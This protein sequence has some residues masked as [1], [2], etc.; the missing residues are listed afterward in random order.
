MGSRC[1]RW[2]WN[3]T[4]AL[5]SPCCGAG[6]LLRCWLPAAAHSLRLAAAAVAAAAALR[7]LSWKQADVETGQHTLRCAAATPSRSLP[8]VER[9]CLSLRPL[10]P[11]ATPARWTSTPASTC[12]SLAASTT[13]SRRRCTWRVGG[14]GWRRAGARVGGRVGVPVGGER[15]SGLRLWVEALPATWRELACKCLLAS[16]PVYPRPL[17]TLSCA[18]STSGNPYQRRY[19]SL[20]DCTNKRGSLVQ[21]VASPLL[22]RR[23]HQWQ[24][25][26]PGAPG[27]SAAAGHDCACD[28]AGEHWP[29][30]GGGGTRGGQSACLG[31]VQVRCSSGGRTCIHRGALRCALLTPCTRHPAAQSLCSPNLSPP[32]IH[33]RCQTLTGSSLGSRC[34][35]IPAPPRQ[36]SASGTWR[37]SAAPCLSARAQRRRGWLSVGRCS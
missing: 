33:R 11:A 36:P 24:P 21:H 32:S 7:V 29:G 5:L 28:R 27:K 2:G 35:R 15:P 3:R 18:G 4:C 26:R 22:S 16:T 17:L 23:L 19:A 25:Q 37:V 8:C 14:C 34:S 20:A 13:K 31:D 10:P 12:C 1:R 6:S 30:G 9:R